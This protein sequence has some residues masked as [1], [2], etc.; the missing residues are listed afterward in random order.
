MST[1]SSIRT[2]AD[3]LARLGDISP[4]RVRFRP[5]P[6][7]A[8]VQDVIAVRQREGVCCELVEGVLLEKP[9]GFNESSLAGFLPG[10][11]L[12][13]RDLFAELDRQG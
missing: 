13:V 2:P 12:P 9:A 11:T 10:F 8:T 4:D 5:P 3:L 1:A 6:G 7:S